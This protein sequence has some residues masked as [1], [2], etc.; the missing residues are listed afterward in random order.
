MKP[1]TPPKR[2]R[3]AP[4]PRRS[5]LPDAVALVLLVLTGLGLVMLF[6]GSPDVW[7]ELHARAMAWARA[8]CLL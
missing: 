1:R 4:P 5:S 2:K 6:A 3:P 7:D 8:G